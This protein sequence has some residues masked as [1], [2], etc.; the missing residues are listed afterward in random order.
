[1]RALI[2]TA[3]IAATPAMAQIDPLAGRYGASSGQD[4]FGAQ[5]LLNQAHSADQ[6][7]R[8]ITPPEFV[9]STAIASCAC[10]AL[11]KEQESK[12]G[13]QKWAQDQQVEAE[14]QARALAQREADRRQNDE[15]DGYRRIA[16]A[17]LSLDRTSIP[18]SQKLV[19]EA[20]Y[21]RIGSTEWLVTIPGNTDAQAIRLVTDRASRDAR[22]ALDRCALSSICSIRLGGVLVTCEHTFA[23]RSYKSDKCLSVTE[24]R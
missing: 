10:Y 2:L 6:Q 12:E 8:A 20:L 13:A 24:L 1:M 16:L 17:D 21:Q 3:L 22:A 15:R 14:R 19:V 4:P 11:W 9:C 5:S 7:C 23:G 18:G